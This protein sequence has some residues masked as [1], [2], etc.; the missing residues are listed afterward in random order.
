M[1]DYT[2][3]FQA[4]AEGTL[5]VGW[6]ACAGSMFIGGSPNKFATSTDGPSNLVAYTANS[7]GADQYSSVLLLG[8]YEPEAFHGPA[9][10]C[11]LGELTAYVLAT[12]AGGSGIGGWRLVRYN[13]GTLTTLDWQPT[14]TTV[15]VG[16]R[17]RLEV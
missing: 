10:R 15:N 3:D 17:L 16:D 12:W 5:T 13:A 11:V 1:A 4:H 8:I 7:V 14:A 6:T 2:D 9:V